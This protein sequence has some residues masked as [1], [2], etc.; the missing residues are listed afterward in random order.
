MTGKSTRDKDLE[1]FRLKISDL[2]ASMDHLNDQLDQ[3]D[4]KLKERSAVESEHEGKCYTCC[5][6]GTE[7]FSVFCEETA[8]GVL[9]R[10]RMHMHSRSCITLSGKRFCTAYPLVYL[11]NSKR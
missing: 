7:T 10:K 2:E 11:I 4:E 3:M 1:A 9:I 5:K 6:C 8:A